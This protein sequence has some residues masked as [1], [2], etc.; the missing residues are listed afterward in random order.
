[1]NKMFQLI[2]GIFIQINSSI[3]VKKNK[4]QVVTALTELAHFIVKVSSFHTL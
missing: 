3:F 1:M 4:L 2:V